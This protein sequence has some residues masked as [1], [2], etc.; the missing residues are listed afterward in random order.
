MEHHRDIRE[1]DGAVWAVYTLIIRF[2]IV[3]IHRSD[4]VKRKFKMHQQILIPVYA[5]VNG[6]NSNFNDQWAFDN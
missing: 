2:I 1:K 4:R 5:S 6:I 3:E